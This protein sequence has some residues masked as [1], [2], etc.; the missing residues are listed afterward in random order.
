[1]IFTKKPLIAF[2]ASISLWSVLANAPQRMG[3]YDFSYESTGNP[4]VLPV[5]VF[6]NGTYT[7]FQFRAGEPFRP[8]S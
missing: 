7:Y 1:M 4:K 3:N 6:D 8:S 5:Q 2:L